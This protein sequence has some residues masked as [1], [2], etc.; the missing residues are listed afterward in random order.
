MSNQNKKNRARRRQQKTGVKYTE[1]LREQD[2]RESLADRSAQTNLLARLGRESAPVDGVDVRILSVD[3]LAP[4]REHC[5][6]CGGGIRWVP[7]GDLKRLRPDEVEEVMALGSDFWA[8]DAWVCLECDSFGIASLPQFEGSPTVLNQ[9]GM[10]SDDF[11]DLLNTCRCG[12]ELEWVDP[13]SI[14]YS[15]RDAYL[16]AKSELGD[17][18][19]LDHSTASVCPA[20]GDTQF[21]AH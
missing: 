4:T 12:A 9:L 21:H 19:L 15:H 7:L 13:A 14:A 8:V 1:A 3:G 6:H 18:V 10:R 20:C 2:A 11:T 16:K 17:H 5:D